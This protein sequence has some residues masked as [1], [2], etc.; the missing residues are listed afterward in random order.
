MDN[1]KR[2]N[3]YCKAI[4]YCIE[5]GYFITPNETKNGN[6][7]SINVGWWEGDGTVATIPLKPKKYTGPE[8]FEIIYNTIGEDKGRSTKKFRELQTD[9][10]YKKD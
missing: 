5:K 9:F 1:Q 10:G 7:K 6:I 4:N 2:W 3:R 8:L